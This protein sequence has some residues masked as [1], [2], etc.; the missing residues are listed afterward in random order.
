MANQQMNFERAKTPAAEERSGILSRTEQLID[1]NPAILQL[2]AHE[3]QAAEAAAARSE[4]SAKVIGFSEF[5]EQRDELH[6]DAIR[7]DVR[8]NYAA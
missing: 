6:L 4:T 7:R 3:Q 8:N 5:R 2:L 1:S